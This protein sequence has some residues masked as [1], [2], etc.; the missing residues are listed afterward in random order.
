MSDR[1]RKLKPCPFCGGEAHIKFFMDQYYID[2]DHTRKCA[3]RP[4]TFLIPSKLVRHHI[5]KWNTR[6]DIQKGE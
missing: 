3:V 4:N 1:K 2:A 6:T 5:K